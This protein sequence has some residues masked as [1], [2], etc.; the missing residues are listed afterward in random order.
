MVYHSPFL[1]A[2][3]MT[4][5]AKTLRSKSLPR[6]TSVPL[7]KGERTI[8]HKSKNGDG[9][10]DLHPIADGID[11]GAVEN[12]WYSIFTKG[13]PLYNDYMASEWGIEKRGDDALFE[14]LCL[15]G[16]QSG[17]SWRTIL[18]KRQAYRCAFHDFDIDQVAQMTGSD[19]DKILSSNATG[20]NMVVRHRGKLESVI[21]NAKLVIAMRKD[22]LVEHHSSFSDFL[23][24][25]VENRP[26]L[27]V[28]KSP[29]E[30]PSKTKESEAM[31]QA[32]KKLG[33]KYVGATT[34][35]SL[36]Q[37]CG[38]VID[39][40]YDTNE[41]KAALARLQKRN[42][43]FQDRCRSCDMDSIYK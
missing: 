6:G 40:P 13:D 22:I 23:W 41:W 37:S 18:N 2:L 28:W 42:G 20:N 38:F 35:Y 39:H 27:N 24:N 32:L 19:I 9:R 3:L 26:I 16:A 21:H 4:A 12:P 29:N 25:F 34:C 10:P 30:I 14:K 7:K 1:H 36:M 43:G 33:F 15:E 11:D 5:T 8:K 31:S 17:L